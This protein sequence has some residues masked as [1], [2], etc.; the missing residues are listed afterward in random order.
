M[1]WLFSLVLG[2]I[3]PVDCASRRD[4]RT[5][6]AGA[7]MARVWREQRRAS[8]GRES[9]RR[10]SSP[11]QVDPTIDEIRS[12]TCPVPSGRTQDRGADQQITQKG[13][14][15]FGSLV[16]W[17][18]HSTPIPTPMC[19]LALHSP[20]A[21]NASLNVRSPNVPFS[22]VRIARRPLL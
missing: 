2:R 9:N 8:V 14:S 5:L 13:C 7:G 16:C 21:T 19:P 10:T 15:G 12:K 3:P 18:R 20:H 4:N 11:L 1:I 6:H 22:T 17:D